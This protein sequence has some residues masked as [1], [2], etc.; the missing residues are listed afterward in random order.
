MEGKA[1]MINH[2]KQVS[3]KTTGQPVKA[4]KAPG[5]KKLPAK[6]SAPKKKK[7]D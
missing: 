1:A 6:K 5:K 2:D 7:V 4:A 3:E